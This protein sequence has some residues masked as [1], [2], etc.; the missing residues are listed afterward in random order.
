[1]CETTTIVLKCCRKKRKKLT[2]QK[3]SYHAR[4]RMREKKRYTN[5]VEKLQKKK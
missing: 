4:D 1:M 5:V 3:I 2:E